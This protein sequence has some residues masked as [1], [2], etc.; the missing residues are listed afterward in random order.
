MSRV[1]E[2]RVPIGLDRETSR[3]NF[4]KTADG[5][6][7]VLRDGHRRLRRRRPRAEAQ[8]EHETYEGSATPRY[9]S[10][11][12]SSTVGRHLL[13]G[14]R[15]RGIFTGPSRADHRDSRTQ[16]AH[17]D[18]LAT[19]LGRGAEV[20]P[21]PQFTFP[22]APSGMRRPSSIGGHLR[23]GWGI[24]A[25]QGAAPAL[26]TRTS[27]LRHLDP[28]RRVP[29]PVRDQHTNLITRRTTSP[30]GGPALQ[31]CRRPS[32]LRIHRLGRRSRDLENHRID[33]LERTS[34]RGQ[35]QEGLLKA[36]AVRARARP[37]PRRS[38]RARRPRRP[39]TWTSPTSLSRW[40]IWR[41][42]LARHGAGCRRPIR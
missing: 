2:S 9:S 26:E 20:P 27:S 34:S 10:S 16:M 35:D 37:P 1:V 17:A 14:G 21:T 11:R 36:L 24:G 33:V 25:Y 4:L 13:R 3:R 22:D 6:R 19:T 30:R 18:A 15:R 32:N 29:A 12:T 38:F 28:Q 5:R 23:D 7:R 40:S 39:A 31:E 42:D 41:T 8:G